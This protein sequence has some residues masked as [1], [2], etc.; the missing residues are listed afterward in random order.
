MI[1][2]EMDVVA[3][4]QSAASLATGQAKA[5]W[6][7]SNCACEAIVEGDYDLQQSQT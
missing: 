7:T 3:L 6:A 1:L 2:A 4:M 5:A